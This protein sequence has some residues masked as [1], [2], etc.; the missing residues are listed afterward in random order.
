[1]LKRFCLILFLVSSL[2]LRARGQ[3]ALTAPRDP[4][5]VALA[6]K[7]VQ[8]LLGGTT[9]RDITLQG[10]ATFTA[11]SDQALAP[12]TLAALG[13]QT[14]LVTLNP[15]N[16]LGREDVTTSS[17]AADQCFGWQGLCGFLFRDG[18]GG[19]IL[20]DQIPAVAW[21]SS[22]RFFFLNFASW[23]SGGAGPNPTKRLEN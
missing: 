6:N 8:A 1:M 22:H 21:P 11:G 2:S 14:S 5:A 3:T 13:N 10:I 16:G 7:A 17:G 19:R 12:A 20:R 18:I 15:T 23:R 4:N 9:R